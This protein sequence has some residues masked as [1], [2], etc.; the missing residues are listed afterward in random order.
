MTVM[1]PRRDAD[2]FSLRL[3]TATRV[4]HEQAEESGFMSAL[5]GGDLSPG[6]YSALAGQL[7]HVYSA[8]ESAAATL[9]EHPVVGPFITDDLYR[10]P[11]LETDLTHLLGSQWRDAV[12]PTPATAAYAERIAMVAQTWPEGYIAHHYTR[13]L[14]DLSGG[15]ILRRGLQRLYDVS[16]DGLR[17]F[18]FERIEKP[19]LFKD[20]Y[21]DRLDQVAFMVDAAGQE[22]VIEEARLAFELNTAL[23]ASLGNRYLRA[24]S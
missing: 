11:A 6:A 20:S 10:L 23:F 4:Q 14:G 16:D 9:R 18:V 19:K 7:W 1:A 12:A 8:L 24:A 15:Q 21:R 13:Y 2:A 17:F 22:R 5:M 3:R